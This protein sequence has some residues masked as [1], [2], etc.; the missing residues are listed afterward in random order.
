MGGEP[1]FIKRGGYRKLDSFML[2]TLI[3][4]TT[5][6]F[7]RSFIR[8]ARQ[9]DQMVQAAR[10][11]RQNIAEGSERAATSRQTEIQLTDVARASLA[12]LRLD[13]EDHLRF[14]QSRPWRD[15]FP[16]CRELAEV[17]L[18]RVETGSDMA[19]R[20]SLVVDENLARFAK[21]LESGDECVIANAMIRL[22]DRADWLLRKQLET[23]GEQFLEQGGF[24][25]R[26][27]AQRLEARAGQA[28]PE[29][30]PLCPECGKPMRK[31]TAKAGPEAGKPFWGCSGYPECHGVRRC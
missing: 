22:C 11:G 12:E 31:R 9:T 5:E 10:S 24:K 29:E 26:L 18:A 21:W 8:S 20:F 2:A 4:Y 6:R 15:D 19:Y 28:E 3:Y 1:L 14:K 17:S 16:E 23:L 13:Y 7:C 27:T 25:E 30:V